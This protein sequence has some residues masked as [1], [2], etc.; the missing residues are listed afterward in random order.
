MRNGW[1]FFEFLANAVQLSAEQRRQALCD[2]D[3]ARVISY[4][5]PTGETAVN[6]VRREQER[7]IGAA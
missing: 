2:P 1:T 7:P 5:D 4:L 6:N 3:T